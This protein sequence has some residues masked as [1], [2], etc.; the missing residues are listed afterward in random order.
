[1]VRKLCTAVGLTV[2]AV[3]AAVSFTG[4][5]AN[6]LP[7]DPCDTIMRMLSTA[8]M[9]RND[10]I[11]WATY[12]ASIGDWRNYQTEM[13]MVDHWDFEIARDEAAAARNHC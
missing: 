13:I 4:G 1:M 9:A 5:T 7:N 10:N 3:M 8:Q 6:A 12:Y 2:A 11:I